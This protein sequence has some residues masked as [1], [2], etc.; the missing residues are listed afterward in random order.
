[1]EQ[2]ADSVRRGDAR[3]DEVLV[4]LLD[5]HGRVGRRDRGRGRPRRSRSEAI[6]GS[7]AT[8]LSSGR[9]SL[10]NVGGATRKVRRNIALPRFDVAKS[11]PGCPPPRGRRNVLCPSSRKRGCRCP[12]PRTSAASSFPARR[13]CSRPPAWT[14]H[15]RRHRAASVGLAAASAHWLSSSPLCVGLWGTGP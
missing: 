4:A 9:Q 6:G 5:Q 11:S 7:A 14:S 13:P 3:R 10:L 12:L 1:M 2:V 15:S 8:S